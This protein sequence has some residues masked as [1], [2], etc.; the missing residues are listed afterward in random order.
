LSR[1]DLG[2]DIHDDN[3]GEELNLFDQPGA[4]YGYPYCWSEGNLPATVGL[5]K[6]TQWATPNSM[7]DGTHTDT[8]CRNTSNVQPPKAVMQAHS[9]PLDLMFYHG[10]AFPSDMVG[11][12]LVTFHGSWNRTAATGY[13]VVVAQFTTDGMPTG[14]VTPL[15]ESTA[16]GDT[17]GGWTH[18]PVA[19]ATGSS[20][21]VYVTSDADGLVMAI[22]HE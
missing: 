16:S 19:L 17:G 3:P 20:G 5:G 4:F 11:S 7:D 21:E 8:W 13:K 2:G 14:T 6:G 18:R 10:N 15:L 22:G 12:A 1:T 9:A